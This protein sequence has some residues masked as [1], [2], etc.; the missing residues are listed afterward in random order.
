MLI[1]HE[2]LRASVKLRESKVY[3]LHLPAHVGAQAQIFTLNMAVGCQS[4][5][6]RLSLSLAVTKR[7]LAPTLSD[8]SLTRSL[9]A[10]SAVYIYECSPHP[11]SPPPPTEWIVTPSAT[12]DLAAAALLRLWLHKIAEKVLRLVTHLTFLFLETGCIA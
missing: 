1:L 4:L 3:I 6:I 12:A 11:P 7:V 10:V 5:L 8:C 9:S 2:G